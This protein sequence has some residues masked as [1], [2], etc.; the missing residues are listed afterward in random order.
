[1]V[2]QHMARLV[3]ELPVAA[4][5]WKFC[6]I[7]ASGVVVNLILFWL[8]LQVHLPVWG[9]WIA[10][11]EGSIISNFTLHSAITWGDLTKHRWSLRLG[12]YHMSVALSTALNLTIFALLWGKTHNWLIDQGV[13]LTIGIGLNYWLSQRFVFVPS[14]TQGSRRK[15]QVMAAPQLAL[16][17]AR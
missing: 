3:R 12:K 6:A 8:A 7:G 1:M 13:A 2:F 9:A 11:T 15:Q 4:R 10:G 16:A 14:L 5:F 17:E